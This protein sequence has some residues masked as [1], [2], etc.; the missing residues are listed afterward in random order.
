MRIV[1]WFTIKVCLQQFIANLACLFLLISA[2]SQTPFQS[3]ALIKYD[4]TTHKTDKSIPFDRAFTLIV[5][6]LS[7]KGIESIHLFEAALKNGE[8]KLVKN[9]FVCRGKKENAAVKDVSLNFLQNVDTLYVFLPPLKPNKDFDINVIRLLPP[10]HRNTLFN[11]NTLLAQGKKADAKTLYDQ[12][13]NALIDPFNNTTYLSLLFNDYETF[14]NA[15][16]D[17]IYKDLQNNA[18]FPASNLLAAN[19]LKAL[20]IATSREVNDFKDAPLLDEICRKGVVENWQRGLIDVGKIY[21]ADFSVDP[22]LA[23]SRISNLETALKLL[24]SV[25][26][27]I[28]RVLSKGVNSQPVNGVTINIANVQSSIRTIRENMQ[29]NL[30][31]LTKKLALLNKSIDANQ[32]IR[33]GTYLAGSTVSSDLKT[34]GGNVLFLDAGL[35]HIVAADVNNKAA[36]IPKL[37][38]GVSIYFRPIDKN[39]RRG[40]FSK[41]F[42]PPENKGCNSDGTF[43]P[44][45]GVVTRATLLQ[46]LSLNIG[47]TFGSMTNKDFDNFYNN[48]SLLVGPAYR[49]ARGFKFSGGAA[50]LKRTSTNPVESNKKVKVGGYL[51]LSVDIDFIQGIKDVTSILF[52]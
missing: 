27:R 21:Q 34:A 25:Q 41:E 11:V 14:Y 4:L 29:S 50:F 45:Y 42:N 8:R 32:G 48:T 47:V 24:D 22:E 49:F 36:Y 15:S 7:A 46:H 43:G 39:T 1:C 37:Y 16:L 28:D 26:R 40:S 5:D 10:E 20:D 12:L 30:S 3:D 2:K 33:Y 17:S 52:K 13:F 23:H 6:K 31:L 51:S 35:A 9:V 18:L 44:D 19:D 38:W